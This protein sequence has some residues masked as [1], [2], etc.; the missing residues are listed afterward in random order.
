M[1]T[2]AIVTTTTD[3]IIFTQITS[4]PTIISIVTGIKIRGT[5]EVSDV[6]S[7]LFCIYT[8]YEKDK[9]NVLSTSELKILIDRVYL[10]LIEK[11]DLIEEANRDACFAMFDASLKLL[12]AV[13]AVKNNVIKCFRLGGC[14]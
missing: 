12:L 4:T 2:P 1:T 11:F 6:P 7:L 5:L 3:D 14:Y 10:H 13:P 9:K 8:E